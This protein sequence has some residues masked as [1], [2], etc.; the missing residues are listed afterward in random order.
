MAY[1]Y[2]CNVQKPSWKLLGVI[3]KTEKDS[4]QSTREMHHEKKGKRQC[5][6]Y[7]KSERLK[8]VPKRGPEIAIN[9]SL[10]FKA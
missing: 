7:P 8:R 5:A 3:V 10:E 1:F 2:P 6:Q 4:A 9:P